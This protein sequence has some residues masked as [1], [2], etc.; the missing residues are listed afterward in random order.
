MVVIDV[1]V[2]AIGWRITAYGAHA[3]LL[4]QEEV[5]LLNRQAL[6]GRL[7]PGA[8]CAHRPMV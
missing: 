1:E 2:L 7:G 6:A 5:V 8:A 4:C 3:T